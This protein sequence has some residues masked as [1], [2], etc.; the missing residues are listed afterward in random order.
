MINKANTKIIGLDT[1]SL[2]QIN[3][4][5]IIVP[6]V[7]KPLNI[8]ALGTWDGFRL[9]KD[10]FSWKGGGNLPQRKV[11]NLSRNYL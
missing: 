9:F 5:A 1:V 8:I 3:K 2:D 6:K 7:F 11:V 10:D 4:N